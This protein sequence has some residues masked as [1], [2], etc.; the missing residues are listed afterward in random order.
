[1]PR[2][3]VLGDIH[4]AI[5]G[6]TFALQDAKE[7]GPFDGVFLVGDLNAILPPTPT[8]S[9][10]DVSTYM[11]HLH[12]IGGLLRFHLPNTPVFFVPGNHDLPPDHEIW[13]KT[14]LRYGF[15]LVDGR[16]TEVAGIKVSGI[17]GGAT[18]NFGFPYDMDEA[19]KHRQLQRDFS[20]GFPDGIIISHGPPDGVR[21]RTA[22]GEE[23][24]SVM[25]REAIS[26]FNGVLFCGHI[27]EARGVETAH[28]GC[29]VVN[30]GSFGPPHAWGGYVVA[31]FRDGQVY[32][33]FAHP[34][35]PEEGY[36]VIWSPP[37]TS[38]L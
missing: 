14:L 10:E 2:F 19:D 32:I 5:G 1:M 38:G 33:D 30:V 7:R 9:V 28:D 37:A 17:G 25:L 8:Q 34:D 13:A 6:L 22:R 11:L 3:L 4:N 35:G 18:T 36:P 16:T 26:T 31:D 29:L 20:D 21:D 24:G 12:A 15:Q 27:H 23:V